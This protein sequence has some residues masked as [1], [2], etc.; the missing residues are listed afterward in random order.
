MNTLSLISFTADSINNINYDLAENKSVSVLTDSTLTVDSLYAVLSGRSEYSGNLSLYAMECRDYPEVIRRLCGFVSLKTGL[1]ED[2]TVK[3]NLL[4]YSAYQGYDQEDIKERIT[5]LLKKIGLW[6][7]RGN[8]VRKL[9][10]LSKLKLRYVM[11]VLHS[12]KILFSFDALSSVDEDETGDIGEFLNYLKTQEKISVVNITT[13]PDLCFRDDDIL[14]VTDSELKAVGSAE[15]IIRLCPLKDLAVISTADNSLDYDGSF[16]VNEDGSFSID[17]EAEN[18]ISQIIKS[19]ALRDNRITCA[20]LKKV[21][22]KDAFNY[23][24]KAVEENI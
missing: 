21:S 9:D 20:Y 6:E 22:L 7:H 8:L 2:S 13:K 4:V 17:I 23:Y 12:P 10:D 19:V 16:S 24:C 18:D 1:Y 11:A 15:E 5:S 14:I 3:N